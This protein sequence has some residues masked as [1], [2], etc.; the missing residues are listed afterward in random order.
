LI[1]LRDGGT[2]NV[3]LPDTNL[4]EVLWF[5]PRTGAQHIGDDI[6]GAGNRPIGSAPNQQSQDWVVLVTLKA[7]QPNNEGADYNEANGLVIIEAENTTSDLDLWQE[8]TSI[9][10]Y[11]GDGF[12]QFNGN[13][14][15]NGPADSPLSYTFKINQGGVYHLHM[16]V[17][18][19]T[20]D[21]R[22]DV[23]NDGYV[24]VEGDYTSPVRT[25]LNTL[26][27][28]TKFYGGAHNSFVWASGNRLDRD[29]E[30]WPAV[31]EFKAGKTYT[32]V[33]SGR[34]KLFKV[35]RIVFRHADVAVGTAQKLSRSETK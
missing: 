33:L 14:V 23:A 16:R 25:P 22:T 34:S 24:R 28:D 7:E 18:R 13:T 35:D 4:Y 21:G 9:S 30:K 10:S 27:T 32:L 31:Y 5:N 6:Q 3:T 11:T 17:A 8:L 29:H 12:I 15:I 2:T 19:E 26:K 1:L 20:V